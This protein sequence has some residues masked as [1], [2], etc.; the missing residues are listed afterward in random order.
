MLDRSERLKAFSK[1]RLTY[2]PGTKLQFH[3]TSAAWVI[4]ELCERITG[5]P[6]AQYLRETLTGPLGLDSIE[7][8]PSVDRQGD[9]AR[10]IRTDDDDSDVNPWGPGI[11]RGQRSLQPES[12][13]T[14][15]SPPRRT[16]RPG[17]RRCCRHPC[18]GARSLKMRCGSA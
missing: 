3:L 12:P 16:W 14:R 15:W 10:F 2:P 8:G 9:V 6:I 5:Q 17:I 11:W 1:W 13:A 4:G 18:G 7:I